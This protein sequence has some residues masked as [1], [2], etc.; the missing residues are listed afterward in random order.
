MHPFYMT[1]HMANLKSGELVMQNAVKNLQ[2]ASLSGV[3]FLLLKTYHLE[4]IT[5]KLSAPY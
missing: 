4:R 3:S 5:Q 1:T 2:S